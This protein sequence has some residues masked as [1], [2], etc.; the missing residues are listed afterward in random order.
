MSFKKDSKNLRNENFLTDK[1]KTKIVT[2]ATSSN[3]FHENV[4]KT[5]I[6]INHYHIT[7]TAKRL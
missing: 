5:N 7:I 2:R 3:T 4:F 1:T 6:K